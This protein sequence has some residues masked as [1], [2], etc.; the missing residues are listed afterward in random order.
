M[1]KKAAASRARCEH[2][3]LQFSS[4]K[5]LGYKQ[6]TWDYRVAAITPSGSGNVKLTDGRTQREAN[7]PT[8][9]PAPLLLPN[10]DLALDPKYPPQSY[11][12]WLRNGNR[13]E[14]TPKRRTIYLAAPPVIEAEVKFVEEWARPKQNGASKIKQPNSADVLEYLKAFYHGMPVKMLPSDVLHFTSEVNDLALK[15]SKSRPNQQITGLSTKSKYGCKGIRSRSTP[16]GIYSHQL[17]QTDLLDAAIW[18]LPNDAYAIL[19]LVEHDVFED[20][21]DEFCCGRAY[22]GSRVA[23][24]STA[25][26]NPA[27]DKIQY[28]ERDHAWPASHCESYLKA[29]LPSP[30]AKAFQR[31]DDP[32]VLVVPTKPYPN[33]PIQEAV[34]AHARLPSLEGKRSPAVLSG[35]WLGRVC[36]TVSH[37]LGHC[38]GMD[39]CVYYACSMQG[40]ASIVEDA[41]QPPYLCPVDLAKVLKAT[42]ANI[43]ERYKAL[44]AFCEQHK[45]IHLFSGYGAWILERLKQLGDAGGPEEEAV[46]QEVIWISD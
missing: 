15:G 31:T 33:N 32:G 20:E 6:P 11:R 8:T 42:E 34:S 24:I 12:S 35:L 2:S 13:N 22:G 43:L 7:S 41:R 21:E 10:D 3:V 4:T 14:V 5:E 29:C 9:F 40:S 36:R 44:L 39:H 37:E 27:L 28:I 46:E 1:P 38:L 45:D 18:A 25:R 26:Y 23:V 30:E 19:L 16:D 17:Q